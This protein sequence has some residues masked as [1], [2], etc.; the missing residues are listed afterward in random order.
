MRYLKYINRIIDSVTN[1]DYNYLNKVTISKYNL[2]NNYFQLKKIYSGTEIAPVLKSNAYGHGLVNVA[3]IMD[4]LNCPFFIVDSLYEAYELYKYNIKTP[5]LII[6]YT[7]P[8]NFTYKKLPFDYAIY[9]ID[10]ARYLNKY[11]PGCKVHIFVDSGMSREGVNLSELNQFVDN[12]SEL[13]NIQIDGVMSHF[14]SADDPDFNQFTQTQISNF[15]KAISILK[16]KG[17]NPKWKHIDATG[18]LLNNKISHFNLARIGLAIYGYTPKY[19]HQ[20]KLFKPVLEFDSTIAQIK[21][22]TK[23]NCVGYNCDY[24]VKNDIIVGILPAGYFEGIDRRLSDRGYV[25]IDGKYCPIIG[26][27]SMNLTTIDISNINNCF[28][29]QQVNI[30]SSSLDDKNNLYSLTSL[31]NTVIYDLLVHIDQSIKRT[32]I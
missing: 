19:N 1:K 31:I 22:I 27:V 16:S 29:G 28:V 20:S 30:Y 23:G 15:D 25:K 10:L 13:K 11:Q 14:A 21:K 8:K 26:K 5:I 24:K 6:G 3:S 2:L 18:G 32:I 4:N 17:I 7:N 12:L 9:D